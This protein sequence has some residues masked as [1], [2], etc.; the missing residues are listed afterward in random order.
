MEKLVNDFIRISL[1]PGLVKEYKRYE[2]RR[3]GYHS[4]SNMRPY[5]GSMQT[6]GGSE[7]IPHD[8]IPGVVRSTL[9][10]TNED[11]QNILA[12]ATCSHL[13]VVYENGTVEDITPDCYIKGNENDITSGQGYGRG[14]YG[15]GGYGRPNAKPPKEQYAMTWS[16]HSLDGQLIANPRGRTI[17]IWS[18]KGK[19]TVY[20]NAPESVDLILVQGETLTAYGCKREGTK[21]S[22]NSP[23]ECSSSRDKENWHNAV[24]PERYQPPLELGHIDCAVS[25]GDA[26]F[27]WTGRGLSLQQRSETNQKAPTEL[28]KVGT[29][30]VASPNAAFAYGDRVYWMDEHFNIKTYNRFESITDLS[31][32]FDRDFRTRV[33]A[34]Q[35]NKIHCSF[36]SKFSEIWWFYPHIDDCEDDMTAE[37]TR[38]IAYN[39]H[40]KH[41]FE[42]KLARSSA[43][44]TFDQREWI[45]TEIFENDGTRNS[46]L[47]VQE[48]GFDNNGIP[49]T[50]HCESTEIEV[51]SIGYCHSLSKIYHNIELLDKTGDGIGATFTIPSKSAEND[52]NFP[53]TN[54]NKGVIYLRTKIKNKLRFSVE[55]SGAV[56]I[57]QNMQIEMRR[58]GRR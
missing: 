7:T 29:S 2:A 10:W 44:S 28:K 47:L 21:S 56:R 40:S 57:G 32:P 58:A 9:A 18:G 30:H 39:V 1:E 19:A 26:V 24:D 23:I 31:P 48:R 54:Q 33:C 20:P 6:I 46:R 4:I 45:A 37:C 43:T 22:N 14:G 3:G 27:V 42:G 41:W 50:G 36:N 25:F 34:S 35:K 52:R 5:Y 53:I 17:Y 13:F 51:G 16:L 38:Y 12:V 11:G 55:V 49:V 15:T 8:S